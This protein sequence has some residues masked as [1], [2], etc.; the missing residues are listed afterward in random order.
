ML[1]DTT[2]IIMVVLNRVKEFDDRE[3]KPLN[4]GGLT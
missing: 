4:G 1:F 2:P 3:M